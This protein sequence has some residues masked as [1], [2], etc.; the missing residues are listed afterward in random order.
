MQALEPRLGVDA[1]EQLTRAI[2]PVVRDDRVERL[3]PFGRLGRID[4]LADRR[5]AGYAVIVVS[6]RHTTH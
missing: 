6:C 3:E 4:V 1:L 2:G 5:L